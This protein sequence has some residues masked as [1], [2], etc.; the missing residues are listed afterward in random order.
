MAKSTQLIMYIH[1]YFIGPA[2]FSFG[3]YK[4][5]GKLNVLFTP[6]YKKDKWEADSVHE[7]LICV[8]THQNNTIM[9]FNF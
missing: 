7:L 4:L 1:I 9:V 6:G 2:M 5:R 3:C 8:T